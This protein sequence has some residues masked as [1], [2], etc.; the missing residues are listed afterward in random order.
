MPC[1]LR[2]QSGDALVPLQVESPIL[3]H[4]ISPPEI[5]LIVLNPNLSKQEAAMGLR[6]AVRQMTATGCSGDSVWN[7]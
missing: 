1:L 6:W 2:D 5:L 7:Q 3:F 4:S